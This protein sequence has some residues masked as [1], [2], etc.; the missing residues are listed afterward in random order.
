MSRS[1]NTKQGFTLIELLVV[2]AVI[3]I[4]STLAIVS[5]A[6]VRAKSRDTKRVADLK[7][8]GNALEL[9]FNDN[10]SYPTIITPGQPLRTASTTYMGKI[11][12]NPTPM[13]DGGCPNQDYQYYY[14]TATNTY[15]VGGCISSAQGSF[16][17]GPVAYHT[18]VGLSNCG[19]SLMDGDGYTYRTVLIAGQCWMAENLK[20]KTNRNG[21]AL[22]NL[23]NG[24]ERDCTQGNGAV[25]GNETH[26]SNG[27]ALYTWSGMMNPD[28]TAGAQGICPDGWHIPTD[29]EQWKLITNLGGAIQAGPKLLV[30]GSVGFGSLMAG[31]RET[32]G[33]TFLYYGSWVNFW[34]STSSGSNATA[35]YFDST[36]SSVTQ[37]S[38]LPKT[39]GFSVRCLKN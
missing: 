35:L 37:D 30:N 11:P 24:S 33:A 34:T 7:Q 23:S 12:N 32:G 20:T 29:I 19:G 31:D 13:T 38:S 9:Y 39:Y 10:G 6:G 28:T 14:I 26:C 8:I 21:V 4:L 27:Y 16:I 22:T 36:G 5:L 2:I 15:V 3:G 18:N 1:V 25:R 17:K